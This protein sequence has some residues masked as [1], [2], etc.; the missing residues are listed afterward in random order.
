VPVPDAVLRRVLAEP[1]VILLK[2]SSLDPGR[3]E[4]ALRARQRRE[5]LTLLS[6][7]EFDCVDYLQAGYDGLLLGGGIFNGY[8][9]NRVMEAVA[10][11][12]LAR[13]QTLQRRMNRLMWATYGGKK[14]TCWL[15]GL[16]YLLVRLG[17][18]RTTV[19]Y[20]GYTLTASCRQA[21]DRMLEREREVLLPWTVKPH[22]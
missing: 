5:G 17:I 10:A 8:L 13:A 20:L 21:I 22:G 18:F 1:K 3:R 11:G 4:V 7:Y 16:K 14:I 6:G 12:D 9:A 15:A 2:D 19:N